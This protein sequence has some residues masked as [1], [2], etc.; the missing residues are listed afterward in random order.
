VTEIPSSDGP[1]QGL[2]YDVGLTAPEW[3]S[4]VFPVDG[5]RASD[6]IDA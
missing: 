3:R 4:F 5:R 2:E 1:D 6:R